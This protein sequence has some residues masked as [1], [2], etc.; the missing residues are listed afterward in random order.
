MTFMDYYCF[1]DYFTTMTSIHSIYLFIPPS[2]CVDEVKD[3]VHFEGSFSID[4]LETHEVNW[5]LSSDE[6]E[7]VSDKNNSGK[8]VAK[9]VRAVVEPMLANHFGTGNSF[10]DKLFE[11]YA[12]HVADHLSRERSKGFYLSIS[13]TTKIV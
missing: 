6:V 7:S 3:I 9:T 1:G 2:P 5:D 10:M 12:V 4:Q 13:L 8:I 11:R